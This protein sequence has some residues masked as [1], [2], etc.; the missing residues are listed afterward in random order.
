MPISASTC[1]PCR[2][3]AAWIPHGLADV[4]RRKSAIGSETSKS[5]RGQPIRDQYNSARIQVPHWLLVAFFRSSTSAQRP[6]PN[7]PHHAIHRHPASPKSLS[8]R[9]WPPFDSAAPRH[10]DIVYKASPY[11]LIQ[12]TICRS[13]N[14]WLLVYAFFK[15]F[16]RIWGVRA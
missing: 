8:G 3:R 14:G 7:V 13:P 11:I 15:S 6:A 2:V 10:H 1:C 16:L 5:R 9:A 4:E 12:Q